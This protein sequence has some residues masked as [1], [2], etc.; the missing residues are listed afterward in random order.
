VSV[1][2]RRLVLALA[3]LLLACSPAAPAP[4]VVLVTLDTTRP[5]RLG[6]YGSRAGTSPVIDAFARESRVFERAWS[7]SPWTLPSHASLLTGKHPTSHG[8]HFDARAG[9]ARL[10]ETLEKRLYDPVRVNRLGDEHTTLA[11][12]LEARGHATAVFAGGP[13]LAPPFGLLQ[14]YA[15]RDAGVSTYAGRSATELTDAALAFVA[16]TPR[17]RPLHLLIN[18][19]D[20]HDPYD[21]PAPFRPDGDAS[22]LALYDAEIRYMDQELLRLFDGLRAAGRYDDAVIVLVSDHGEAFGEHG[23]RWHGNWHFEELLRMALLVRLPGG[24]NAGQRVLDPVSSV[25]LLPLLADE[26]GL[27][28]PDG[29]EGVPVG[30]RELV[31]AESFPD[32]MAIR[33]HGPE[34]DRGLVTAIRWPWKLT[35]STRGLRRLHRLDTDPGEQRQLLPKAAP[36]LAA[37]LAAA[38]AALVPPRR[39]DRPE[40]VEAQTRERLRELGYIE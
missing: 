14:G 10:S 13:W 19:F 36:G 1:Q 37:E 30:S 21:P 31:L 23:F 33:M 27:D 32:P 34:H 2:R 15:H 5:D 4:D 3:A 8:A 20:P 9:D 6:V 24:R 12:L 40:G 35:V 38:R 29:V 25:D 17:E 26:L 39:A 22:D 16:A 18:Y 11:E 28:L 7:T